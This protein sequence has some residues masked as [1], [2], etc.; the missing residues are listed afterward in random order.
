MLKMMKAIGKKI[1]D[2]L[3][4]Q[5]EISCGVIVVQPKSDIFLLM[6]SWSS[7]GTCTLGV[8]CLALRSSPSVVIVGI[9]DMLGKS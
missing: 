9:F 6:L 2:L 7:S 3:S 1:R 4:I 5:L 8:E